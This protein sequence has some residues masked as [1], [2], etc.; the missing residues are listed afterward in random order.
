MAPTGRPQNGLAP[1]PGGRPLPGSTESEQDA[2]AL[3]TIPAPYVVAAA[4]TVLLIGA[5]IFK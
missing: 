5:L 2:D 4:L 3:Y 1:A